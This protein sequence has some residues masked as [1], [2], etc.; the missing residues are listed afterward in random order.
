MPSF[1]CFE[2]RS[3]P[4]VRGSSI[5]LIVE[6]GSSKESKAS[7]LKTLPPQK[8][9]LTNPIKSPNNLRKAF[10]SIYTTPYDPLRIPIS[11]H[12]S[13]L[14][15]PPWIPLQDLASNRFLAQVL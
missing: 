14:Q 11:L 6:L 9:S 7:T 3:D 5:L 2:N 10:I 4:F 13:L 15:K 12:K 1:V 8:L